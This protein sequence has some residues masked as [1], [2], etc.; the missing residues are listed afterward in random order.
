MGKVIDINEHKK[1]K[2]PKL[3]KLLKDF[4]YC[5]VPYLVV[6]GMVAIVLITCLIAYFTGNTFITKF[7]IWIL[8]AI[9]AEVIF[10]RL[11]IYIMKNMYDLNE[12]SDIKDQQLGGKK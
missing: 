10:V 1:K 12:L 9:P 2:R 6:P 3:S 4:I 5:I 7:F 11:M 8:T